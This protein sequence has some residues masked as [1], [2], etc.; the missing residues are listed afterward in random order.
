MLKDHFF[1]LEL[2]KKTLLNRVKQVRKTLFKTYRVGRETEPKSLEIKSSGVFK[3]C[4]EL[5]EKCCRMLG[6]ED[7]CTG[8]GHVHS[9]MSLTELDYYFPQRLEDSEAS[10]KT[11]QKDVSQVPEGD[12]AGL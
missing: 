7:C 10:M 12:I 1:L 8:S 9:L 2:S 5:V 3:C 11:V 6:E 4:G